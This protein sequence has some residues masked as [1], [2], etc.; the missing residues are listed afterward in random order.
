MKKSI[1]I[2][3]VSLVSMIFAE[4]SISGVSYFGY[5]MNNMNAN[6]E[7][8]K[9]RGFELNRVYLTYKN[10]I[11]DKASFK[12]QADMQNKNET[13][14]TAYY[15]Y[16]KKAQFDLKVADGAK[17]MIGMQGMNMFNV[18]EKTWGNRFISQTALHMNKWS[19]AAD[20]GVG[21]KL[22]MGCPFIESNKISGSLLVTNGEGYKSTSS[23]NNEKISFQALYGEERLDKK[24]GFNVG[25][26]YSTLT[27]DS[28]EA[29]EDDLS[30]AKEGG[31]GTVMGGFAG[32]AGFGARVGLEYHMGTDLDIEDYSSSSTLMSVYANYSLSFIDGLSLFGRYDMVD[33]GNAD[34]ATSDINEGDEDN[35]STMMAGVIYNCTDGLTFSPH[36]VQTAEGT[37]DPMMDFKV[38]FQLKF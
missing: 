19:A 21:A 5:S 20:L 35:V 26:V 3:I 23:D 4:G 36:I 27:Y 37:G 24:D 11:S 18:S 31:T 15:M 38:L 7:D 25:A 13:E 6:L 10:K 30:S 29:V 17:L 16:I 14:K 8:D 28:V 2:V 1:M 34:D 9:E 33:L 32:F 22:S 12:F